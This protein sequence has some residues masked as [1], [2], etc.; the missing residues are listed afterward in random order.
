MKWWQLPLKGERALGIP[1]GDRVAW[2][3]SDGGS[4]GRICTHFC[5]DTVRLFETK[6]KRDDFVLRNSYE[7]VAKRGFVENV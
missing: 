7:K 1:N 3:Y 5:T 2:E 6:K 4:K